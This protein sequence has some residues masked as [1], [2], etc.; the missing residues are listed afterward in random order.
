MSKPIQKDQTRE[1]LKIR[2]TLRTFVDGIDIFSVIFFIWEFLKCVRNILKHGKA[3][4]YRYVKKKGWHGL[5]LGPHFNRLLYLM[6][7]RFVFPCRN[8]L[9]TEYFKCF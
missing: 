6:I 4:C 1:A 5:R 2:K 3:I 9:K 8:K 7:F